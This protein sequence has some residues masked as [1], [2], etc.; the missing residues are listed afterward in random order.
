[1]KKSV[2]TRRQRILFLCR[3]AMIAALYVVLTYLAGM[4]GLASGA[5]QIRLS[6]ALC[7][8]PLF[9][10]AAIP[11]CIL[12]CFLSNLLLACPWQDIVFGTLATAIGVGAGYLLRRWGFW[13]V[14][15]PTVISN[16]LIVPAVLVYAYGLKMALWFYVLT[17]CIGEILSVC[18]LGALLYFGVRKHA[19]RLFGTE[20]SVFSNRKGF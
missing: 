9:T 6:E 2:L 3:S 15:L 5:I 12:G 7:I 17:V 18:A 20:A 16:S 1:M 13:A 14:A 4:L 8:L 11:G 19:G 10:P